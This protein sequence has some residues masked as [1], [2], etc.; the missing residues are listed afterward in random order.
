MIFLCLKFA[1]C[2][3][4]VNI[5][6]SLKPRP[7]NPAVDKYEILIWKAFDDV[8]RR[9]SHLP[10]LDPPLNEMQNR[11]QKLHVVV[12]KANS[13]AHKV[14]LSHETV[15]DWSQLQIFVELPQTCSRRMGKCHHS[16]NV[17]VRLDCWWVFIVGY[18]PTTARCQSKANVNKFVIDD[19][20]TMWSRHQFSSEEELSL[21]K[22]VDFQ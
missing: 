6:R 20:L 19:V 17:E 3:E 11:C 18:A 10:P 16:V 12:N 22:R 4:I 14:F 1:A 2:R 15:W 8:D 7:L 13:C 5:T 21:Q 9:G